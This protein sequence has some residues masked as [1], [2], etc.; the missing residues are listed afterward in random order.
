[1]LWGLGQLLYGHVSPAP[2]TEDE[3]KSFMEVCPPFRAACYGL[4]MAWYNYSLRPPDGPAAAGRN[5]LMMA[6]YLPYGRRFVTDDWAQTN[7]LREV[8]AASSIG[9]EILSVKKL[10]ESL[11]ISV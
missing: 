11:I 5:D 1:V 8:A 7:D 10:E 2:V 3:I 9:C 4:V 6:T